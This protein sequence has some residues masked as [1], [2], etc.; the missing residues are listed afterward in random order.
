MLGELQEPFLRVGP[1]GVAVDDG[2]PTAGAAGLVP[3]G[4]TQRGWTLRRSARSVTWHDLRVSRLVPGRTVASR[5]I[6][7]RVDGGN[8]AIA[9]RTRRPPAPALWPWLLLP[10]PAAGGWTFLSPGAAAEGGE[11]PLPEL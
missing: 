9:G 5:R 3:K 8:G 11:L 7:L 2:S 10:A 4:R 6:P 1:A